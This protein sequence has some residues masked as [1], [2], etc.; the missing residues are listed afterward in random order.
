MHSFLR[1][2]FEAP[3]PISF[4]FCLDVAPAAPILTLFSLLT[5]VLGDDGIKATTTGSF[6]ETV[7]LMNRDDLL[8]KL[9]YL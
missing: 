6:T 9:A 7:I 4:L 3:D 2:P 8:H 1:F 5:E